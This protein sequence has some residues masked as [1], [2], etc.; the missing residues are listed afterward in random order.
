[1]KCICCSSEKVKY[2]VKSELYYCYDCNN[3]YDRDDIEKYI[4]SYRADSEEIGSPHLILLHL[5]MSIPIVNLI[6]TF[7]VQGAIVKP[8]YKKDFACRFISQI[9][10]MAVIILLAATKFKDLKYEAILEK[11]KQTDILHTRVMKNEQ[12]VS[13]YV[14]ESII[15]S[16]VNSITHNTVTTT[17]DGRP[18]V[19]NEAWAYLEDNVVTGLTAK[20]IIYDCI[21]TKIAILVQNSDVVDEYGKDAYFN[22]GL[23]LHSSDAITDG[24]DH[25][26]NLYENYALQLYY[27]DRAGDYLNVGTDDIFNHK[28]RYSL[29]SKKNYKV[30]LLYDADERIIGIA[31]KEV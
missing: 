23:I 9:L 14:N 1:M 7:F 30:T 12:Y 15:D 10:I 11:V 5:F 13:T 8:H 18:I 21:N 16:V 4:K 29:D 27:D 3:F 6:T 22:V 26:F 19:L 24:K 20:A 17:G 31:F 2:D 28:V 25:F